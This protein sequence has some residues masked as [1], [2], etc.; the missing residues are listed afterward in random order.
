MESIQRFDPG[1]RP[2]TPI[3]PITAITI[4]PTIMKTARSVGAPVNILEIFELKEFIASL[5]NIIS[6]IPP[7]SS[8]KEIA[9]IIL[10]SNYVNSNQSGKVE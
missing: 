3:A 1:I 4:P 2:I 6:K 8:A 7:R 5:P 10:F 9:L